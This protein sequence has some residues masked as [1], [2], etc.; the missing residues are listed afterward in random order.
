MWHVLF[1]FGTT[2][3]D[4]PSASVFIVMLNRLHQPFHLFG[5]RLHLGSAASAASRDGY[6]SVTP[7]GRS[8]SD[9]SMASSS[10]AALD[11]VRQLFYHFEPFL[12]VFQ[13]YTT[14]HALCGVL[15][16]VP[17][18][19]NLMADLVFAILML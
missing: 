7:S 17:V 18:L 6:D 4:P 15:C 9:R 19:I 11:P 16:F 12:T 3:P 8:R 10:R 2:T 13:L 1:S 14:P 5:F